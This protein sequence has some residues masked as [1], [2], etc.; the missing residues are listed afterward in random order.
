MWAHAPSGAV[1]W[2]NRVILAGLAETGNAEQRA[3][4]NARIEEVDPAIRYSAYN[5]GTGPARSVAAQDRGTARARETSRGCGARGPRRRTGASHPGQLSGGGDERELAELIRTRMAAAGASDAALATLA[6][7]LEALAAQEGG[8]V[9]A[10]Q[11]IPWAGQQVPVQNASVAALL[12]AIDAQRAAAL[13]KPTATEVL[14][15]FDKLLSTCSDAATAALAD[16]KT[17]EVRAIDRHG[18]VA[19]RVCVREEGAGTVLTRRLHRAALVTVMRWRAQAVVA[20]SKSAKSDEATLQLR[21]VHA[22]ASFQRLL[23]LADRTLLV[24]EQTLRR[25]PGGATPGQDPRGACGCEWWHA[26]WF[27]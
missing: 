9:A 13:A 21:H 23:A 7:R 16:L 10:L 24:I 4:C 26:L 8:P 14:A 15:G 19:A 6:S 22:F 3:V 25:I 1:A 20:K 2:L 17:N 11:E 18:P 12:A 5:L 27:V